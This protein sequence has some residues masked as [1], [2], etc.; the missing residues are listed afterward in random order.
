M[1]ASNIEV[2]QNPKTPAKILAQLKSKSNNSNKSS[3]KD[4]K[5]PEK[6]G[7]NAYNDKLWDAFL[8]S[9]YAKYPDTELS[10]DADFVE[11]YPDGTEYSETYYY[12]YESDIVDVTKKLYESGA[13][14]DEAAV[15]QIWEVGTWKDVE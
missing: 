3:R 14:I 2:A 7:Y 13:S 8:D 1:A 10:G 9:F 5:Q 11:L 6:I 15:S 4:K 12:M